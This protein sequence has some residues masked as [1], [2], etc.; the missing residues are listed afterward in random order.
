MASVAAG[1]III[2]FVLCDVRQKQ[3]HA[4][5]NSTNCMTFQSFSLM[6]RKHVTDNGFFWVLLLLL[7]TNLRFVGFAISVEVAVAI[8]KAFYRPGMCVTQSRR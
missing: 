1:F 4:T 6:I 3:M 2:T 5:I 7:C 8:T